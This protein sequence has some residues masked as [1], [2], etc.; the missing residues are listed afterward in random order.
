MDPWTH[1]PMTGGWW[2]TRWVWFGR[3]RRSEWEPTHRTVRGRHGPTDDG[4]EFENDLKA[5]VCWG[6][7]GVLPLGPREL[8]LPVL[9]HFPNC[10]ISRLLIQI[11][12]PLHM[13]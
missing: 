6:S 11:E 12:T 5:F 7:F 8:H 13:T 2:Q 10:N 9:E 4:R 1:G 3:L